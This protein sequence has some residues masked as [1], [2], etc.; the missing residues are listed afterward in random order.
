MTEYDKLVLN[1]RDY[2]IFHSSAWAKILCDAYGYNPAYVA[3]INEN[4]FD[5]LMPLMEIN[6]HLT[7]KR[8][9]GLPFSDFCGPL[10]KDYRSHQTFLSFLIEQ[11]KISGWD[12]IEI[13]GGEDIF[14]KFNPSVS[15][16][17]HEIEFSGNVTG[18]QSEFRSSTRRN[19][20]KAEKNGIKVE[21]LGSEDAVNAFYRLNCLTRKKHGLPPQPFSFFKSVYRHII[22]KN[23]GMIALASQ[24]SKYVAGALFLHFGKKALYK[25]GASDPNYDELRANYLIFDKVIKWYSDQGFF[26]LNF[27]RTSTENYGLRQFKTGWGA[28]EMLIYY[29]KYDIQRG[30]F[31]TDRQKENGFYNKIFRNIPVPVSVFIGSKLYRHVG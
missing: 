20:K 22:S 8:A 13:R 10:T 18:L 26:A 29:Y 3:L 23:S 19:I 1:S 17:T 9:V 31:R 12:Y 4:K 16:L 2:T 24:N 30:M 6:S 11:G 7:G 5:F 21:L 28:K 15:Y 14:N 27:G 25:Y